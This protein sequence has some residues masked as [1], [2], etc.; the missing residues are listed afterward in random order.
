MQ[1]KGEYT[2]KYN[3]LTKMKCS[4]LVIY[5]TYNPVSYNTTF[6]FGNLSVA[7]NHMIFYFLF[8]LG[9]AAVSATSS[10]E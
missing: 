3:H 5:I 2:E 4:I 10:Q 9:D 1:D 7:L 8:V 6:T